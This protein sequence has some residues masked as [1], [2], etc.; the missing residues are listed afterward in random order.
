[1]AHIPQFERKLKK[2][3][4]PSMCYYVDAIYRIFRR[5][6]DSMQL[7]GCVWTGHNVHGLRLKSFEQT[8]WC[9]NQQRWTP[10][11]FFTYCI[12]CWMSLLKNG[13]PSSIC[14]SKATLASNC[15][16]PDHQPCCN[17]SLS[18]TQACHK[19]VGENCHSLQKPTLSV[20]CIVD[21]TV[22]RV[23]AV[24]SI[25]YCSQQ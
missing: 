24:G 18:S 8:N 4:Q 5:A 2:L 17:C 6:Y 19:H 25:G 13:L 3:L 1:M 9:L 20:N 11:L 15:T 16:D 10:L 14:A 7:N 12:G 21:N 23:C 22:T